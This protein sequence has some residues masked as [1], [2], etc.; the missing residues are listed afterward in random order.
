LRGGSSIVSVGQVYVLPTCEN[1]AIYIALIHK[2]RR[3]LV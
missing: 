1:P 2:G 3:P